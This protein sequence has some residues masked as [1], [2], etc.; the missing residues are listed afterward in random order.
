MGQVLAPWLKISN[1][2]SHLVCLWGNSTDLSLLIDMTE[3][4]IKALQATGCEQLAQSEK[5]I[6]DN[7]LPKLW[8]TVKG[9]KAQGGGRIDFILDNAGFELYCDFVYGEDICWDHQV[10]LLVANVHG[11]N[12]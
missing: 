10:G 6:L 12:V 5:N 8:E 9:F 2:K 4:Q 3:E 1:P 11:R 7:N